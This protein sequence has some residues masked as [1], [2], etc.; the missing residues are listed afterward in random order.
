MN[1]AQ[2]GAATTDKDTNMNTNTTTAKRW[3]AGFVMAAGLGTAI[4]SGGALAAADTGAATTN[5]GASGSTSGTTTGPAYDGVSSRKLQEQVGVKKVNR[6]I[7][8]KSAAG[9]SALDDWE[10]PNV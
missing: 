8:V 2:P 7:P 10:A 5:S 3:L 9:S 1:A 4:I 6:G